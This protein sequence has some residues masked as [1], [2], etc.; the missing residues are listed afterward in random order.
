[1]KPVWSLLIRIGRTDLIRS[2]IQL[3][4]SLYTVFRRLIGLQFF[5]NCLG[6]SPFGILKN[7]KSPGSDG[8]TSEF[9]KFFW[10]NLGTF[11][12][13]SIN[14]GYK[15]GQLSITQKQGIVACIPKGDK[16]RQFM[17]N[18]RKD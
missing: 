8:F 10:N 13:R 7:E 2:A 5:I 3:E 11:V 4:A 1:M 16:P 6:L 12:I 9:F 17:K 15:T 18:W 14:Y